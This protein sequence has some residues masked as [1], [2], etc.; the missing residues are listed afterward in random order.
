MLVL[1]FE[2]V[3][4]VFDR[5]VLDHFSGLDIVAK[6][7]VDRVFFGFIFVFFWI[8]ECG[9]VLSIVCVDV[10]LEWFLVF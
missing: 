10:Y 3:F 2:E 5:C 8:T 4:G 1:F 9:R 7:L 6:V